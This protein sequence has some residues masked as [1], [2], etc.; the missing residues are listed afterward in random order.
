M[1]WLSLSNLLRVC[2]VAA[3]AI[4]A[5]VSGT[6]AVLAQK[7]TVVPVKARRGVKYFD[8][9]NPR[10]ATL[11]P[12]PAKF[13][14]RLGD[15]HWRSYEGGFAR[16]P[17]AGRGGKAAF[18]VQRAQF[19]EAARGIAQ[20]VDLHQ[21]TPRSLLISGWSRAR[22]VSGS[23]DADYSLYAD[24]TYQDGSHLWGQSAAF[25]TGT[26]DWQRV[27]YRIAPAKPIRSV[28][29]YALFRAHTGQAWFS[30][31][32]LAELKAPLGTA[33][34]D[35]LPVRILPS[36][37][38]LANSSTYATKDGLQLRLEAGSGRV[39]SLQI[40]GRELSQSGVG[41][42]FLASTLR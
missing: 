17:N 10:L 11:A 3:L 1:K 22:N 28:T 12:A 27:E 21:K 40:G 13:V 37:K 30:D 36:Q 20:Q 29:L 34:F 2:R 5:S 41:S 38:A 19:D 26:H 31:L 14:N 4:M 39:K 24:V 35:A 42:G 8:R 32:R 7:V 23:S 18:F 6:N 25:A 9:A 16:Q 33:F 15:A